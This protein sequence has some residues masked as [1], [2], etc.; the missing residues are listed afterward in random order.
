MNI[1]NIV[2]NKCIHNFFSEEPPQNRSNIYLGPWRTSSSSW[3]EGAERLDMTSIPAACGPA[4][5]VRTTQASPASFHD[6]ERRGWTA[7]NT[8]RPPSILVGE[9]WSAA[10]AVT[11]PSG[12]F[13]RKRVG[14]RTLAVAAADGDD[15]RRRMWPRRDRCAAASYW[16]DGG[17]ALSLCPPL[18]SLVE[19]R[20]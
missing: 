8:P 15:R 11:A 13:P 9:Q 12:V 14:K 6:F 7:Y 16:A 1:A 4:G 3:F 20:S 10:S 5:R 18:V 2:Q 17:A 19:R